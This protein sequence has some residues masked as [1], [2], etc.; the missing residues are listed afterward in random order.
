[1]KRGEI[2]DLPVYE[3]YGNWIEDG[4]MPYADFRV[5]YPPLALPVFAAPALASDSEDGYRT[6]SRR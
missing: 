3:R 4:R 6:S 2:S 5:E 1:M